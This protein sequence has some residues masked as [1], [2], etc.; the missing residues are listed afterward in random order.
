MPDTPLHTRAVPPSPT[1][2]P[3]RAGSAVLARMGTL[4]LALACAA[5]G[6]VW[7]HPG[8]LHTLATSHSA[9]AGLM[10]PWSGADHWLAMLAVGLWSALVVPRQ[11]SD[12]LGAPLGF[13]GLLLVGAVLGLAQGDAG[14]AVWAGWVEPMVAASLLVFGLLVA[15]RLRLSIVGSA[16]LVGVFA[17]CHG[18]AHGQELASADAHAAVLAGL[19]CS[20]LLLHGLGF[21][22]G[23]A[24]QRWQPRLQ[25]ALAHTAGAL[26]GGYGTLL[27]VGMA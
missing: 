16:A 11:R 23:H 18:L 9:I 1:T 26:L 6:A 21:A 14:T 5:P 22:L 12:R 13:V 25:R 10:H 27:L 2:H 24:V 19:T 8:D 17:L 3:A 20:T 15:A 7:A 4:T